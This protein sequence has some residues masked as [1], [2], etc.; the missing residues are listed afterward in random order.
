MDRWINDRGQPVAD[1]ARQ[2]YQKTLAGWALDV[3]SPPPIDRLASAR[4]RK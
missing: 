2:L 4:S 1:F 3:V